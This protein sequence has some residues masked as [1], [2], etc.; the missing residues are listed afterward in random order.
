MSYT[1]KERFTTKTPRTPR[2]RRRNSFEEQKTRR[3]TTETQRRRENKEGILSKE[4]RRIDF[5]ENH[6]LCILRVLFPFFVFSLSPFLVFLVSW[7]RTL[8]PP[9]F[10]EKDPGCIAA[11]GAQS[12]GVDESARQGGKA[13]SSVGGTAVSHVLHGAGPTR[14]RLGQSG[15]LACWEGGAATWP[16]RVERMGSPWS[17]GSLTGSDGGPLVASSFTYVAG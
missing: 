13:P 2:R 14:R 8:S 6:C 16:F 5:F 17:S 9:R 15:A 11:L 1:S 10:H 7:W 4:M 3:L 12:S